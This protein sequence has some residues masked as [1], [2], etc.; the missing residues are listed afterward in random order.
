M[1]EFYTL[2]EVYRG[3]IEPKKGGFCG[4]H[5]L[6]GLS[7]RFS[8]AGGSFLRRFFGAGFLHKILRKRWRGVTFFGFAAVFLRAFFGDGLFSASHARSA[9]RSS[10][11]RSRVMP[12]VVPRRLAL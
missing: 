11:P 6:F 4:N 12:S 3:E 9:A 7:F 10:N 5:V 2:G 1:A 8:S